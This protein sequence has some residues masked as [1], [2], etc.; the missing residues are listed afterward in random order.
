MRT[1]DDT[2]SL[3][4]YVDAA[5]LIV[6]AGATTVAEVDECEQQISSLEKLLGIVMNKVETS[7]KDYY[8]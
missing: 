7:T 8:Y 4:P 5:L 6:A 3:L 2:I 1:S